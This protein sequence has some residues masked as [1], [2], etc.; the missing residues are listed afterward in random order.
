MD[1]SETLEQL[2]VRAYDLIA[3]IEALQRELRDANDLISQ[4]QQ[5]SLQ[6]PSILPAPINGDG[7]LGATPHN[8]NGSH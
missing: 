6:D 7:E 8:I 2:K 5:E 3:V 4:K 1:S